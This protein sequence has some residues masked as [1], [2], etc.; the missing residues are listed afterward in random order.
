MDTNSL[1]PLLKL[2]MVFAVILLG[3][4]W[5]AGI[6]ASILLGSLFLALLFQIGLLAWAK[7]GMHGF[8]QEKVILLAVIVLPI[9]YLSDMP[10]RTGQGWRLMQHVSKVLIWPRLRLIFFPALI[11]VLTTPLHVC[12]ILS[13]GYFRTS[14]EEALKKLLAPCALMLLFAI[15]YSFFLIRWE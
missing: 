2:A 8:F 3:I 14:L 1:W 7:I 15:G 9:L 11:G 4:R 5:K 10:E 13:C 6:G 12:L